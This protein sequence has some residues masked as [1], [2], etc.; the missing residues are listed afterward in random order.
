M[1]PPKHTW[2]TAWFVLT[3]PIIIMDLSYCFLRPRSMI[4]GDLSWFFVPY[5]TYQYIDHVY[6]IEALQRGEGFPNAQSL[7]NL[8]ETILNLAYVYA[9]HVRAWNPAPVLGLVGA[10]MTLSKTVLY[11]AQEYYCNWCAVGHNSLRDIIMYWF[12][13]SLPWV[14][15]PAL[16]ILRLGRD[17]GADLE[18]AARVADAAKSK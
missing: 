18:V 15:V 9:T 8:F 14:V 16:I 7:L 2:V 11:W 12:L 6:G 1:A 5:H 3:A 4:G 17:V 10:S 13:G